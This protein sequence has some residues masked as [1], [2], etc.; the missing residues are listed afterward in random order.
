MT[1]IQEV[2]QAAAG[3]VAE[4]ANTIASAPTIQQGIA[5]AKP[6]LF[7]STAMIVEETIAKLLGLSEPEIT[8]AVGL[9][10]H[11]LSNRA[12]VNTVHNA[13]KT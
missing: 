1:L 3:T 10:T 13:N 2:E 8:L 5:A 4:A 11:I 9:I 12:L 6:S 7:M